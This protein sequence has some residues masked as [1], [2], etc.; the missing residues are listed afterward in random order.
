MSTN[1]YPIFDTLLGKPEK[2]KLLNQKGIVIWLIGLSGSGK[3]T[4]ARALENQLYK[5]GNFTQLLDGDNLR[6]GLNK[7]LGF[8]NEDRVEN[9]RRT[10]ETARLFANS[11]V[12]TICSFI[13]PTE[14]SRIQIR[15]ILKDLYFE[16]FVECPL[17]ECE[18]RDVKGIYAKARK[19]EIKNFTGIDAPFEDPVNPNLVLQTHLHDLEKCLEKL[20]NSIQ[21]RI[22]LD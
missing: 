11:G 6:T 7:D 5:E 9:L 14:V 18:R 4:I 16:V 20:R 19:G 12:I 22:K 17:E 15:E 2:E 1:I 13:T 21:D 8:S 10:A 3:S